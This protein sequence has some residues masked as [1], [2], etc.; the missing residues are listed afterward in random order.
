[1]TQLLD[2]LTDLSKNRRGFTLIEMLF[3]MAIVGIIFATLS[4]GIFQLLT[5]SAENITKESAIR[6]MDTARI[7]LVQD[8]QAANA[9]ELPSTSVLV[10]TTN[11]NNFTF[12]K[13]VTASDDTTII[14]TIT[15]DGNLQRKVVNKASGTFTVSI[16][17]SDI[18]S[19]SYDSA[20]RK[21]TLSSGLQPNLTTRTFIINP[22]VGSGNLTIT[23]ASLPGGTIGVSY[24]T[25]VEASGGT[26]PYI[27]N[28]SPMSGV[29]PPGLSLSQS[30]NSLVVSGTPTTASTTPYSFTVKVSDSSSPSPASAT[31]TLSILISWANRLTV[32][33]YP[34]PTTAGANHTFTVT[35]QDASGNTATGYLGTVRFTSNDSQAVLPADYTFTSSDHGVHTFSATLKTAGTRSIT[36]TD[37]ATSSVMGTQSGITVN[38]LTASKLGFI[39]PAQANIVVGSPSGVIRIQTQ[40][41]YGN[42]SNVAATITV[43]LTS[44]SGNG[45]FSLNS[46]PWSNI[47]SVTIP[48]GN[49]LASFYYKDTTIGSPVITAAKSGL[50]SG[51]QTE[52]VQAGRLDHYSISAVSSPKV[53]GTAFNVTIQAQDSSSNNITSGS[54]ASENINITFGLPDAGAAPVTASTSAGAATVSMVM[55]TAQSGQSITFTGVISLKS[56]TSNTFTV[57]V[58]AVSKFV[59][60]GSAAQASGASNALTITATDAGGNKITTYTGSKSLTFSGASSIGAYTP[61]VTNSSGTA[62]NFGTATSITF[63][64]GVTSA[65]GSMVL[66]KAETASI[67]A[68]AS[69]MTTLT[70]LN[71]TVSVGSTNATQSTLTPT[72]ASI[73]ANGISTQVLTV[74][75]RDAY[76][77]NL[78]T[79][80]S[81]VTIT[82]SSGTGTIG[83]VTDNGNGTYTATVTSPT[84]SGSGVFVATLGGS[85]VKSGTGTQTQ[86]TITY[87]PGAADAT[88][89]TLTPTSASITANGSSTQ[90]LTVQ[91]RDSY[92]NNLTIGG[93]TV[94]ITKSSGTG[95]IGS[96]T[97]NSNGTY[98]ATVTSPAAAG[99]G[100]FVATLGGSAVKS[101]TGSQT[102]STI[103]YVA[104]PTITAITPPTGS[105]AGGNS[106]TITGSGFYGGGSSSTVS[107]VTFGGTNVTSYSVTSNTTMTVVTP[108]H[109]VG[110]V[111]VVVTATY[112]STTMTGGF[113]YGYITFRAVGTN[114]TGSSTSLTM[115]AP[116]GAVTNDVLIAF[117]ADHSTTGGQSTAPTGWQGRGYAYSSGK[118]FQVFTAVVGANGLTGTSWS[119]TGLTS[120]TQGVILD[121]YNAGTTGYGSLDTTVS[122][123]YNNSGTTGTTSIT[124]TTANDMLI[125][126]FTSSAN[127]CTWSNERCATAGTMTEVFDA[128]YSSYSSIAIAQLLWSSTGATGVSSATMNTN[129]TNEGILLALHP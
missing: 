70:P 57:N 8:F 76:G 90:V 30:G 128:A 64:N 37:T 3:A 24:S 62:V 18:S 122:V 89:S 1:M 56:D 111:N 107:A 73:T 85:A 34:S 42:P 101:G 106:V 50:T 105:L 91:T 2:K 97:D 117:I 108:A 9:G 49:N 47:A 32:A 39:T 44:T 99:S 25:T 84:S 77:N 126:A 114:A 16:I 23:T 72:S 12:I 11:N 109:A 115:T 94:T 113:T 35:A 82:K 17:G 123:R 6:G 124:S 102:Q 95:T 13:S 52:T 78:T 81:T 92:G 5:I 121:Y 4:T 120:R 100:I 21:V 80:G 69:G 20:T 26:P 112:G 45:K 98:T 38:A 119:F 93:S 7:W 61:T 67:S 29:L 14:Y 79:G 46:T 15:S 31:R 103:T 55:A 19:L 110:A 58:G 60:T 33:G 118:R 41:T 68:T 59:I 28:T 22:R 48:S 125:A 104:A 40:D 74:Q 27:W 54:D 116:S 86:T 51:T 63:T 65:G 53:A 129:T 75:A 43:N 83:S 71:V 66:Y 10:N 87:I 127:G 96:V 88:Q 36:A